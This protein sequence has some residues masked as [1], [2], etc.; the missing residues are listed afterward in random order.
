MTQFRTWL[1]LVNS[2]SGENKT[3][4]MRL[5]RALKASGA[6]ALRHGV[7]ILPKTDS[8]RTLFAAQAEEVVAAGG[9]AHIF[10]FESEDAAQQRG[11]VRRFDRAANYAELFAEVQ[12]LK[13]AMAHLGEGE[14]RRRLVALRRDVA[15]LSAIDFFPGAARRQ[16]ESALTDV[17]AALNARFAPDEPHP[18]RGTVPVREKARYRGRIWATRQ[19]PWIDRVACAWLIRRFIDPKARFV[20]LNKPKDCPKAA[21][22]FDFDGAEFSHL[23]ARVTFEVLVASFGLGKDRGLARLGALVHYL[24]I[25]GIAVPEA[26]GFA[27]IMAGARAQQANDDKLLQSISAVLDALYASYLEPSGEVL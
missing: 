23:G 15:A 27:A 5:W 9:S 16:L 6:A 13:A 26:A 4:R 7:Y 8:A 10:S 19:R 20:W 22:G 24:D 21:V 14:A 1:M 2:V 3:A 12:A 17:E 25:G 18:A 11:L